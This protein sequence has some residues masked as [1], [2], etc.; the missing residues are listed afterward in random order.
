M[1]SPVLGAGVRFLYAAM[2]DEIRED[3]RRTLRDLIDCRSATDPNFRRSV[4]QCF[5]AGAFP[6]N[7]CAGAVSGPLVRLFGCTAG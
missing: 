4:L 3:P 2:P 5:L 7:P 6:D 1:K